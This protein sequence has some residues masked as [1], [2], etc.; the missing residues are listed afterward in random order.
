MERVERRRWEEQEIRR[1]EEIRERE[2]ARKLYSLDHGL[3]WTEAD[4]ELV[5]ERNWETSRDGVHGG[6]VRFV[7]KF[8]KLETPLEQPEEEKLRE[9]CRNQAVLFDDGHDSILFTDPG[10]Q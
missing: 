8:P 6:K 7:S 4:E 3:I 5:K 1:L 9:K 10:V 2:M